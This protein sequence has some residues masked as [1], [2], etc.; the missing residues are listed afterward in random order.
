MVLL[1]IRCCII[2]VPN[3]RRKKWQKNSRKRVGLAW[4]LPRD[5]CAKLIDFLKEIIFS[6]EFFDSNRI[7][8]KSFSRKR[9]LPFH[10]II[11]F[12]MNLIKG[13]YQDELD[14]F[15]KTIRQSRTFLRVVTKSAFCKARKSS[16]PRLSKNSTNL[17]S[18]SL[19]AISNPR[20]GMAWVYPGL[21]RW[22]HVGGSQQRCHCRAFWGMEFRQ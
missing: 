19:K 7:G 20:H 1:F 16:S 6:K 21:C 8:S 13:S 9:I 15:F 10:Y 12:L 4:N 5:L 2:L 11:F 3:E 17:P 14:Y 22:L 18:T